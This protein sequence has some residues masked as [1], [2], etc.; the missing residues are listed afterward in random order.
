M[1]LAFLRLHQRKKSEP[2]FAFR[3]LISLLYIFFFPRAL[4]GA[5]STSVPL[6]LRGY[7][8]P[9]VF[10]PLLLLHSLLLSSLSYRPIST[11]FVTSLTDRNISLST[12]MHTLQFSVSLWTFPTFTMERSSREVSYC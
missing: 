12:S 9:L 10:T 3:R 2:S 1:S 8:Y 6:Y 4:R 5:E 7:L 11:T